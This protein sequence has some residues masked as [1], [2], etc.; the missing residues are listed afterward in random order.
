MTSHAAGPQSTPNPREPD[1][2]RHAGPAGWALD[3]PDGFVRAAYW[4]LLGRAPEPSRLAD[5]TG[6]LQRGQPRAWVLLGVMGPLEFRERYNRLL[7]APDDGQGDAV[8][9]NALQALGANA[10][11]VEAAYA[12]ILGR[13]G[14]PDGCATYTALLDRGT[15][16]SVVAHALLRSDE[17]AGRYRELCP[18]SGV[19]PRDVQLCELA[20]P[21]KWDN[22]EWMAVLEEL[23]LPAG[24]RLAMHRKA[25]E[26]TQAAWGLRRLGALHDSASVLSVGAGH[27][28][29]AYWF[30]NQA[31]SVIGID[32]YHGEWRSIGSAE[33]DVR[34][35]THPEEFA[36]FAYRR[37][38]LRFLQMDGRAL[39]FRDETF[40]V[41]YSLSSVEHFGGWPGARRAV[42]EMARVVRP[43]GTIV[44][45]TEWC[46]SGPPHG[47][48]FQPDEVRAL[49]AVPGLELIEPID[50]RVWR[51][52]EGAIVDL[53]HNP[54]QVPHMLLKVG[55]TVFTSVVVFLRKG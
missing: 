3:D 52:N 43:G 30:A 37:D 19:V 8:L 7:A 34:V 9:E 51:R 47:E 17:F 12:C 33:G 36:P 55:E 23:Q 15:P 40:D 26:F 27:E 13:P 22:P 35:V 28:S 38:R 42:E 24:T 6:Y 32:L 53:H 14:D 11:F 39:A 49:V 29:L 44:L 46:V 1:P 20:N 18:A 54:F 31:A 50:D 5:L 41:A 21:A 45:A 10:A 16:R 2:L 48:V 25:Y 4:L